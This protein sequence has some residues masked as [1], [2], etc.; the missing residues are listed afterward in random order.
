MKL[1]ILL[2]HF[3]FPKNQD[4]FEEKKIYI[5]YIWK[6]RIADHWVSG[7]HHVWVDVE[8]RHLMRMW[9]PFNGWSGKL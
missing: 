7:P 6:D 8:T 4:I 1:Y 9:Q 3:S 5:E 2:I